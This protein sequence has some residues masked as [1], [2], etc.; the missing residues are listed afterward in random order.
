MIQYGSPQTNYA[1]GDNYY[2][3]L[4]DKVDQSGRDI[5]RAADGAFDLEDGLGQI[6]EGADRLSNGAKKAQKGSTRRQIG[7]ASCR[8]RV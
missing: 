1:V 3:Q 7:R 4:F 2:V 6:S 8:E 5:K